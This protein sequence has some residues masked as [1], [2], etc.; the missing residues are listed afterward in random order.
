MHV[1][2]I[3]A[4]YGAAGSVVG[5]AVAERLGVPFLDRAIPTAVAGDLGI[6]LEHALARDE[7]APGWLA[8]VLAVTAPM[9]AEWQVVPQPPHAVPLPDDRL[10]ACTQAAIRR[11]IAG[12]GGVILGRA[13][14]MVLRNHPT[15][16]HVRL[17]GDP[18]RRVQ[19][20]A[21]LLGITEQE[22]QEALPRNDQARTAYVRRFYR[23]DPT[24]PEHYHLVLDSTRLAP[25]VC[26]DLIV[27]AVS[28]ARRC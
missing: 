20:A 13:G 1:V 3:S 11:C 24:R 26:T 22:A 7:H 17:D 8:R 10:L 16:L 14:A 6:T 15:A 5:P 25:E 12:R 18:D 21:M 9:S 2:T 19:Q 28:A 27:A 23:A 4:T